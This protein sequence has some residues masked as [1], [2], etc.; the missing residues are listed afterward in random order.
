MPALLRLRV[1][2][3]PGELDAALAAGVDPASDPALALRADRL[4]DAGTRRALAS[5][6]QNLLDAAE[7]PPTAWRYGDPRPRI[8]RGA[9]LAARPHLEALMERLRWPAAVP[10][11][12]VALAAQ[13][14][15]ESASPVYTAEAD[16][17]VAE[18]A[19]SILELLG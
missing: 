4:A 19:D 14:A 18:F 8:R 16:A 3:Q 17:S 7:E 5:T 10:T 11:R 15:W 6:L 2:L 1:A 12:A 13:L 9:V